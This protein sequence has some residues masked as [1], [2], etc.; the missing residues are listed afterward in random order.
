KY[1][2]KKA[3]FILERIFST[4]TLQIL[5]MD[6]IRL[7][8]IDEMLGYD[9]KINTMVFG[10]EKKSVA[11]YPDERPESQYGADAETTMKYSINALLVLL[12]N[13][14]ANISIM[15]RPGVSIIS[16]HFSNAS[17]EVFQVG[18]VVQSYNT[19]VA[20]LASNQNMMF[21][22]TTSN[23]M[24]ELLNTLGALIKGLTLLA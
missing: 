11:R 20:P 9:K 14:F 15:Q 24:R 17:K 21:R 18:T 7:R 4:L 5:A 1:V 8:Q 19:A 6:A 22:Q 13:R 2:K 3:Q 10:I 16:D 12:D 23:Q